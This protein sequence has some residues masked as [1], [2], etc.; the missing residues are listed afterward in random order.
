M[1]ADEADFWASENNIGDVPLLSK[2]RASTDTKAVYEEICKEIT[3]GVQ[4]D[5][6]IYCFPQIPIFYS[7]CDRWDPGVRSKV[8]WFDVSTDEA[9]EADI[10]IL[11][12]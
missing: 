6:T 4:E 8:E 12:E 3:E 1:G 9:V 7:L 11:K 2:I 5:E 10:D